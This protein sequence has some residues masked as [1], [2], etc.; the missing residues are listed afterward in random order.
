MF[1][2]NLN[3]LQMAVKGNSDEVDINALLRVG[4][5]ILCLFLYDIYDNAYIISI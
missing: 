4:L 3:D 2:S 1:Q 5:G